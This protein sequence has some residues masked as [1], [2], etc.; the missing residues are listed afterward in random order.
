MSV[1][2]LEMEFSGVKHMHIFEKNWADAIET[3]MLFDVSVRTHCCMTSCRAYVAKEMADW[4]KGRW[5][6]RPASSASTQN[7]Y[8]IVFVL[9]VINRAESSIHFV[10]SSDWMQ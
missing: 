7:L 6:S 10:F 9:N 5:W 3:S 8:G 1:I 4:Y 2:I